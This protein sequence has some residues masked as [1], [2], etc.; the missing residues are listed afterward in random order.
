MKMHRNIVHIAQH[1]WLKDFSTKERL[2]FYIID[3]EVCGMNLLQFIKM[4][5]QKASIKGISVT[6]IWSISQQ[7]RL[8]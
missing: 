2:S 3:M 4:S 7:L 1:G 6:E 5:F 8:A